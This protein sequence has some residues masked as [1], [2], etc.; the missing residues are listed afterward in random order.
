[1]PAVSRFRNF[2][3][4]QDEQHLFWEAQ[5]VYNAWHSEAG[6]FLLHPASGTDPT[7]VNLTNSPA[8][9]YVGK[10]D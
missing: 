1:M 2:E 5:D 8:L 3:W 9:V 10:N 6:I 4:V 7:E